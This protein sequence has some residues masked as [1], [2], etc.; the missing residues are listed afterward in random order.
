MVCLIWGYILQA[1]DQ[2]W[3]RRFHFYLCVHLL[4]LLFPF[5]NQVS[6]ICYEVAVLSS[7]ACSY[8]VYVYVC[9]QNVWV[10]P[11][12]LLLLIHGSREHRTGHLMW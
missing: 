7:C 1:V 6:D 11:D 12:S 10:V 8:A 4:H 3:S 2:F 9:V 5:Q